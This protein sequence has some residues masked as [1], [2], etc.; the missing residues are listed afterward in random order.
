MGGKMTDE[1]LE[2]WFKLR[3]FVLN[4]PNYDFEMSTWCYK[5]KD[6]NGNDCGTAACLAGSALLACGMQVYNSTV[7][8]EACELLGLDP[9][10][11]GMES[12]L[13]AFDCQGWP[14][15]LKIK[16][17]EARANRK[18]KEKKEAAVEL[19]DRM[20]CEE[21]KRRKENG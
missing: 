18:S 4:E 21:Q 9:H 19:I 3:E 12:G 20:I 2:N 5:P 17:K 16:Y 8:V 1:Q 6:I 10:A 15:D 7:V 14:E 13:F 11:H